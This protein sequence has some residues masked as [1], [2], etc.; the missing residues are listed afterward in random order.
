M[1]F[2]MPT[3]EL[4]D[5]VLRECFSSLHACVEAVGSKVDSLNEPHGPISNVRHELRA[6]RQGELAL[7]SKQN[8]AMAE[9]GEAT[10]KAVALLAKSGATN[11]RQV[12][13]LTTRCGTMETKIT[14]M[15][16]QV[17]AL[18]TQGAY[19]KGVLDGLAQRFQ[20][21]TTDDVRSGATPQKVSPAVG[22]VRPWKAVAVLMTLLGAW[23]GIRAF[24]Q[25]VAPIAE[26]AT[27][28]YLHGN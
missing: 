21:P 9:Q 3:G 24:V 22:S 26:I 11:T 13:A 1:K 5:D 12:K 15:G 8:A 28:S 27:K 7:L 20:T 25:W 18:V 14:G 10:K 4:T 19:S 16:G 6:V 17:E 2:E 23:E